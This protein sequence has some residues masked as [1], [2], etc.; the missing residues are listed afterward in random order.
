MNELITLQPLTLTPPRG[1]DDLIADIGNGENGF[2]GTSLFRGDVTRKEFLLGGLR[3]RDPALVDSGRVAQTIFLVIGDSTHV[4]GMVRVRHY[5]N[6]ALRIKGGH[7]G[8][9]IRPSFRGKGFARRALNLAL[10]ELRV[11]GELRALITVDSNN[12]GSIKVIEACGGVVESEDI[13]AASGEAFLRYWIE[14]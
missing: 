12:P 7:I 2:G 14:L 3:D 5:L 13:D 1:F 10:Q 8:Y 9:Y 6:D 4:I 11:L